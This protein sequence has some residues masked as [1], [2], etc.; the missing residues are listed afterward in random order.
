[1]KQ[2]LEATL[3]PKWLLPGIAA[4][5]MIVIAIIVVTVFFG[6]RYVRVQQELKLG[7]KYLDELDYE[8]AIIHFTNAIE[9][10]E[11]SVP[12][13]LGRGE[14]YLNLE[15]NEQAE[16]DYTMV[17]E[18]SQAENIE[19]YV[20]RAEAYG[21]Q[22]KKEAA[23]KDLLRAQELGLPEQEADTLRQEFISIKPLTAD[24]LIW[25]VEP[26]YEYQQ[27]VPLHGQRFSTLSGGFCDG[28]EDVLLYGYRE[29]STS[30]YSQL[31]QYYGVQLA[32]GSWRIYC[33]PEHTDSRTIPAE[34]PTEY[35]VNLDPGGISDYPASVENMEVHFPAPWHVLQY[36]EMIDDPDELYYDT[37]TKQALLS[38]GLYR[39]S[40]QPVAGKIHKPYPAGKMSTENTG[41]ADMIPFEIW[42]GDETLD[43]DHYYDVIQAQTQQFPKCYIGTDGQPITDFLYDGAEDFSEGLAA[44]SIDGKWG[45]IDETGT[46]VTEFIYEG[47][48]LKKELDDMTY[49]SR[50]LVTGYPCTSDTMVVRKDGKVGLLYRDGSVLIEFGQFEDMAPAFNNELWAKQD[51]LWGLIDL[52]DAKAKAGVQTELSVPAE[53]EL[54]DPEWKAEIWGKYV[55]TD[56]ILPDYPK[57][58]SKVSSFLNGRVGT[59]YLREELTTYT[60]PGNSYPAGQTIPEGESLEIM[61]EMSSMP[62]WV[63]VCWRGSA[64]D[65]MESSYIGGW[66]EKSSVMS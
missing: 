10:D 45:Y 20:G 17:I 14:S 47:A 5:V 23:E 59:Y 60:G 52:A 26:T 8:Q 43:I 13:Y 40:L 32:D 21:K 11:R 30:S 39:I 63:Y 54:P 53:T 1:M 12:A 61:G 37:Y 31:P 41:T 65:G 64:M 29:T 35:I 44:C 9:V 3:K 6:R 56:D 55:D 7:Q 33:M 48:W 28:E 51:G 38:A 46:P 34:N 66:V 50:T 49:E 22:G 25:V 42:Y 4:V 58:V 62:G 16:A 19:A 15:Q 27:V 57:T 24:Q 2:H 36:R 18:T